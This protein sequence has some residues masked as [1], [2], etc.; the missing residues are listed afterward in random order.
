VKTRELDTPRKQRSIALED[1][2]PDHDGALEFKGLGKSKIECICPGCGK[3][4][5]MKVY[6][7]GRGVPRKFCQS[8]R[9]RET[10][11]DDDA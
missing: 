8:C 6:W 3:I 1:A 5:I 7:T 2:D 10:P 11:I 4:H 9:D